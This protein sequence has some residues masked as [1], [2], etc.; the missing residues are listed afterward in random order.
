MPASLQTAADYLAA[1]RFYYFREAFSDA[2]AMIAHAVE[3]TRASQPQLT[4]FADIL[5]LSGLAGASVSPKRHATSSRLPSAALAAG[6]EGVV[7]MEAIIARDGTVAEARTTSPLS[8]FDDSAIGAVRQ[9]QFTPTLLN[10]MPVEVF[11]TVT[12]NF[13]IR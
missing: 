12:V 1:A 3:L 8:L 11:M 2:E 9:W 4:P 6:A 10:G 7:T 5:A 13:R